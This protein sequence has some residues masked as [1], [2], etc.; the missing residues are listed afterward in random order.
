MNPLRKRCPG[1][2]PQTV[3]RG[4]RILQFNMD[5]DCHDEHDDDEEEEDD[6][7]SKYEEG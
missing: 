2:R 7:D 6:F 4:K 1:K 5:D 3:W